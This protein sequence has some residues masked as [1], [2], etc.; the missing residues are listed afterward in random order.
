MQPKAFPANA[1]ER[2]PVRRR[3]S[4]FAQRDRYFGFD[5]AEWR[6]QFVRGVSGELSLATLRASDGRQGSDAHDE[7]GAI[8]QDEQP[9][10]ED[11]FGVD[12]R[13]SNP[14]DVG[15]AFSRHQPARAKRL[16]AHAERGAIDV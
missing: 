5:D 8:D 2:R 16:R 3:V 12:Q 14:L 6:P 15:Q 11:Q 10:A 9:G 13:I 7:Q 1:F 4:F